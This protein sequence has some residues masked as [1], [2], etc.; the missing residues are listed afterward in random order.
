[1]LQLIEALRALR[2][3]HPNLGVLAFDDEGFY[4]QQRSRDALMADVLRAAHAG[5][6]EVRLLVLTGNYHARLDQPRQL[7]SGDR[8][9]QPPMPMAGLLQDLGVVSVNLAAR[10]GAYWGCT[11]PTTPCGVQTL[12][13][14]SQ[15]VGDQQTVAARAL[16]PG[17]SFH[18]QV[19]LP[20]FQASAPVVVPDPAKPGADSAGR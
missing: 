15:P 3:R 14:R 17:S 12:P 13:T 9:I 8:M 7:R 20:R 2:G 16:P 5:K 1:M 19:E 6:P 11:T 18:L 10:G 4:Q